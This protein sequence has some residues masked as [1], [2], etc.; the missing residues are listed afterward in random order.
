MADDTK[1]LV[2][3][4]RKFSAQFGGLIKAAELLGNVVSIEQATN[5][6]QQRLDAARAEESR[7]EGERT[8]RKKKYESDL[9]RIE[10]IARRIT[11]EAEVK[12]RATLVES[13]A[14]ADEVIRQAHADGAAIVKAKAEEADAHGKAAAQY[15]VMI[16]RQNAEIASQKTQL[17][18]LHAKLVEAQGRMD[19][20]ERKRAE[21][22]ARI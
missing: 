15:V 18:A 1:R 12:A 10:E 21:L 17:E 9:E 19:E 3:D 14:A 6:A 13:N 22:R 11:A 7:F 20:I 2:E 5:E 8:V 16:T 4:A